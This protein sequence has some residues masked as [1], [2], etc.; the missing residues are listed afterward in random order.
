MYTD[1]REGYGILDHRDFRFEGTFKMD[2]FVQGKVEFKD[3]GEVLTK[4]ISF[5]GTFLNGVY[6]GPQCKVKLRNEMMYEGSFVNGMQEGEGTNI[7]SSNT[8]IY[9]KYWK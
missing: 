5:E 7:D 2:D 8:K 6:H 3:K 9:S 4:E 1:K